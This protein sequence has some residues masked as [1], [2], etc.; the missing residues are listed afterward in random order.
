[1]ANT[2]VREAIRTGRKRVR[3]V[4]AGPTGLVLLVRWNAISHHYRCPSLEARFLLAV[5]ARRTAAC[6]SR[7]LEVHGWYT[8]FV[9]KDRNPANRATDH[10]RVLRNFSR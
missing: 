4:T 8:E 5:A 1:M 9:R 3:S 10:T 2:A 7:G 6:L